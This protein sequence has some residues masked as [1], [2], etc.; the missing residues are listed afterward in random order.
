M[1]KPV[2]I[3]I[4]HTT[5]DSL[6]SQFN[7]VNEYH[8]TQGFDKS[9]LGYYCGYHLFVERTGLVIRARKD[10]ESGIHAIGSNN[11]SIGVCLAGN[12]DVSFPTKPQIDTVKRLAKQYALPI[13]WHREVQEHRTCP[14]KNLI[15]H[16]IFEDAPKIESSIDT[17]KA[18][19]IQKQLSWAR[20][21][22]AQLT[23]LINKLLKRV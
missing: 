10:E 7:V 13:K 4:H 9:E 8:R 18:I 15:V 5:V 12:F 14:G 16:S 20:E 3:V 19:E 22:V 1:N 17:T 23:L 11:K 2:Y 21:V 6:Q